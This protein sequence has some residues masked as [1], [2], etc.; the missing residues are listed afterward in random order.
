MF[1]LDTEGADDPLFN[2]LCRLWQWSGLIGMALAVGL[3][4]I[5]VFGFDAT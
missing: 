5:T 1:A 2:W 3:A 4:V